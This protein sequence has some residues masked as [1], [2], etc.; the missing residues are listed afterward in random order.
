MSI[1]IYIAIFFLWSDYKTLIQRVMCHFGQKR[2]TPC[3]LCSDR[4]HQIWN[5]CM[6][7]SLYIP[8]RK[9]AAVTRESKNRPVESILRK[10]SSSRIYLWYPRTLEAIIVIRLGFSSLRIWFLYT[11]KEK[12]LIHVWMSRWKYE[13]CVFWEGWLPWRNWR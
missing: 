13:G 7:K 8:C 1:Q 2:I 9:V 5:L 10:I 11:R 3:C 12:R 6:C 4:L